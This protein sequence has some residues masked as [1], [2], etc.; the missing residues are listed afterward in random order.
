MPQKTALEVKTEL[1]KLY[2]NKQLREKPGPYMLTSDAFKCIGERDNHR[3]AFGQIVKELLE[4]DGYTLIDLHKNYQ[5]IGIFRISR[6]E[7]KLDLFDEY[8]LQLV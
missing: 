8:D 5:I 2:K 7:R 6:L 1:I 4:Q 3:H